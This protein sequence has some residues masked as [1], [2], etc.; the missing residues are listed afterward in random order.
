[1]KVSLQI[2]GNKYYAVLYGKFGDD[3][4]AKYKW[5]STGIDAVKG[6]LREA[7]AKANDILADAITEIKNPK[8][9]FT[10][11]IN[12]WYKL[13]ETTTEHTTLDTYRYI[14]DTHMIPYFSGNI[15]DIKPIDIIEY[16]NSKLETQSQSSLQKHKQ[17]LNTIFND[18]VKLDIIGKNPTHNI[19]VPKSVKPKKDKEVLLTPDE[20]KRLLEAFKNERLYP[21]V[22]TCLIYGLRRSEVLG[23]KWSAIDFDKNTLAINHT[24]VQNKEIVRKDG[25]KTKGSK[26]VFDLVPDVKDVLLKVRAEQK[27]L[28]NSLEDY[29]KSD[30]V[31]TWENGELYRP[32]FITKKFKKILKANNLPD[33]RFHDL[34]HSTASIMFDNGNDI[35]AIKIWL[36]HSDIS[37]TSNIYTHISQNRKKIIGNSIADSLKI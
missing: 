25:T 22:Y 5:V 35:E 24:V 37:T 21:I 3:T 13:K 14:I 29:K 18:A 36:R 34:R 4:K 19:N 20:A 27:T 16:Y 7:E 1:M 8:I 9:T 11:F 12:D 2:K 6:N 32:D 23:L 30:Y 26:A 15:E 33:M 17:I 28:E 10:A 31:F